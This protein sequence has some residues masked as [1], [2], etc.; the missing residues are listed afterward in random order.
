MAYEK[1]YPGGWQSGE[2]GGTP[3]T[4]EALNHMEKGIEA[5]VPLD[6]ST[7]MTGQLKLQGDYA[8]LA[9]A[10]GT[11]AIILFD[12]AGDSANRRHLMMVDR[13]TTP[14][15]KYGVFYRTTTNGAGKDYQI[16][17]ECNKPS[18]TYTG[19]GSAASRIIPIDSIGG[20]IVIQSLHGTVFVTN[21]GCIGHSGTTVRALNYD[22]VQ[23]FASNLTIKSTDAFVNANGTTYNYQVL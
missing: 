15:D 10:K 13:N 17:T 1:Y 21:K 6:G 2:T 8:R 12:K 14:N 16:L 3:I 5:A 23:F 18:G 19:N 9:G 11:A 20:A 4:P 22:A 7:P